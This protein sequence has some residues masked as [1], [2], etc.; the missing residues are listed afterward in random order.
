MYSVAI[1]Y[2]SHWELKHRC[3]TLITLKVTNRNW[4]FAIL[5]LECS[6]IAAKHE[7]KLLSWVFLNEKRINQLK[8]HLII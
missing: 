1:L 5:I 3:Q 4:Q 2:L 8:K 6:F 7:L